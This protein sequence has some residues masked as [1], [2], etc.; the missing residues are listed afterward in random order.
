M[1]SPRAPLPDSRPLPRPLPR[2]PAWPGDATGDY[3]HGLL[4]D[5]VAVVEVLDGGAVTKPMVRPRR[6]S[7]AAP[8][9]PHLALR[10][11]CWLPP[12]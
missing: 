3:E 8:R 4:A 5:A 2:P 7:H 12:A 11:V 9:T 10:A 1:L 6:T